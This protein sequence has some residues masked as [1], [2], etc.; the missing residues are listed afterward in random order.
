M[1][2][3][4]T[5]FVLDTTLAWL[6][7]VTPDLARRFPMN[8]LWFVGMARNGSNGIG[9]VRPRRVCDHQALHH[10]TKG[11]IPARTIHL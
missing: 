6:V 3:N 10:L 8:F 4:E 7:E 5:P 9:D 1:Q 11:L 2:L